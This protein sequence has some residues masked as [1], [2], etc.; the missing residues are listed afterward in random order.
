METNCSN[1][2]CKSNDKKATTFVEFDMLTDLGIRDH[3]EYLCDNCAENVL[4][5]GLANKLKLQF[6]L[7]RFMSM[8]DYNRLLDTFVP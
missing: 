7:K 6:K 2:C 1:V 5:H 4:I 8:D 3:Q